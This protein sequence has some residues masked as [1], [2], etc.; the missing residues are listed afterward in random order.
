MEVWQYSLREFMGEHYGRVLQG[1]DESFS[2]TVFEQTLDSDW[3][4]LKG[5][6]DAGLSWVNS[7]Q[8]VLNSGPTYT[9]D[10]VEFVIFID[11]TPKQERTIIALARES[12][13][14]EWEAAGTYNERALY[15]KEKY[16]RK[17]L[18]KHLIM[19]KFRALGGRPP[20]PNRHYTKNGYNALI[21]FW[22]SEVNAA[23]EKGE[24]VPDQVRHD[25]ENV[26]YID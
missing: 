18:H 15:I 25:Y 5:F 14:E 11:P 9:I 7:I 3:K 21:N 26:K 8:E 23:I 16:R 19:K 2:G 1:L 17:G 12:G 6:I 10:H 13:E 22:V 24:N 20:N 4:N